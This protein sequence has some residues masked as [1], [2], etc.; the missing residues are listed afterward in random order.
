MRETYSSLL[1]TAKD[2]VVDSSTTSST[3]IST[4]EVFLAREINNAIQELFQTIRNYKTISTP[5]TMSTVANQVYYHYPPGLLN[6]ESV[7]M[8]IGDVVYPLKP[9]NSQGQ[10]D[11]WQ[12][13][14][15]TSSDVPQ[16][17]FP[18]Q[19][20][21][22]I[23]PT[24]A[25]VKTVTI[26]GNYLP[27]RISASDHIVGTASITQ[28]SAALTGTD[29]LWTSDMV[30]RW[31]CQ[32]DSSG[33]SVGEW[34]R[35]TSYTSATSLTLETVFEESSLT[36]STYVIGQSPEIPE[37]LHQFI[38]FRAAANYIATSRRN[39]VKAQPLL[40]YYYTGDYSNGNRNGVI[41]GGVLGIINR[42]KQ[43][44]R[45]NSQI[46]NMHQSQ[47]DHWRDERWSTQL[48]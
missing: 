28:N 13:L 27:R 44:G 16:F 32:T 21:F 39:A 42:Y 22:G 6:I 5:R 17:Y 8:T 9:V 15:I 45:S 14:D 12:Q 23:Y 1:Q 29:S 41:Q 11:N 48:S 37:E 4:S 2:L 30:G 31:F 20:D 34:Y 35:I 46:I 26:V 33:L 19:Y 43:T 38:P 18:R 25:D 7:T 10:W 24:P 3:S 47:Y 36:D 40:N